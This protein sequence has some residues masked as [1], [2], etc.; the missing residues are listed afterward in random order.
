MNTI[1]AMTVMVS[2]TL[3]WHFLNVRYHVL[4]ACVKDLIRCLRYDDHQRCVVRRRLGK[5]RIMQIVSVF[6][7]LY[8][9]G[10]KIWPL[11]RR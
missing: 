3:F 7:L 6:I 11:T 8:A 5:A 2:R 10:T 4:I 9:H 1:E